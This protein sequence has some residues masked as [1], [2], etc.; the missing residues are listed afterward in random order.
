MN[1]IQYKPVTGKQNDLIE[2]FIDWVF[3]DD[4]EFIRDLKAS[5]F[6]TFACGNV[7]VYGEY[8]VAVKYSKGKVYLADAAPDN[9]GN[10]R[11]F[12]T[13][14]RAVKMIKKS[15]AVIVRAPQSELNRIAGDYSHKAK[16]FVE[17]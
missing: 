9:K 16:N 2:V 1:Y 17:G 6:Q 10:Q 8:I 11:A 5:K 15:G 7:L 14:M 12:K 4:Y 13:Y 3:T